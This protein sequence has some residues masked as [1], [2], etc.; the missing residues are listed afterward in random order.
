MRFERHLALTAVV[1]GIV[2]IVHY[3]IGTKVVL[4][5]E[6]TLKAEYI[7]DSILDIVWAT[8]FFLY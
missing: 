4:L 8:C 1:T 2:L 6:N 3:I 7:Y 5:G